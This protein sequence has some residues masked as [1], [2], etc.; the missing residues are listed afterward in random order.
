MKK[1]IFGV[2]IGIVISTSTIYAKQIN[3]TIQ[4]AYNNIKIS[5]FGQ[6]CIPKDADG[7]IVEPFIYEETTYVPIRTIS[8]AFGKR[9]DWND[10]TKTVEIRQPFSS[11]EVSEGQ[12][13]IKK[14]FDYFA[15]H[16]QYDMQK[17]LSEPF[18][19]YDISDSV[20]GMKSATLSGIEY[21]E[22]HSNWS[23][24]TLIFNCTFDNVEFSPNASN[25]NGDNKSA[26]Y[27]L[28]HKDEDY[29][30]ISDFVSGL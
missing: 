4:V 12:E 14:F 3:D 29:Y 20:Y 1:V 19:Q 2:I 18:S 7:D 15:E 13:V 6:E 23:T 30:T 11:Q 24:G 10:E 5:V 16:N 26:C 8:Q 22:E 27:I 9:V 28:V 17:L 21:V 25:N